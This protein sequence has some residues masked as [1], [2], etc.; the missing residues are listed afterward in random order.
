MTS[1]S[2]YRALLIVYPKSFRNEF[3][4]DIVQLFKDQR[5]HAGRSGLAIWAQALPDL[6]L[7]GMYERKGSIMSKKTLAVIGAVAITELVF[8]GLI[9]VVGGSASRALLVLGIVSL[10][11]LAL[12]GV[13]SLVGRKIEAST[14]E[15]STEKKMSF[16]RLWW[17][18]VPMLFSFVYVVIGV[19]PLVENPSVGDLVPIALGLLLA[20]L[21]IF[22]L[23]SRFRRSDNL[24][25]WA[26]LISC[27]PAFT[28]T[29][30]PPV[31]LLGA[32]GVLGAVSDMFMN[33]RQ[34]SLK[35]A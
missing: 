17:T 13:S 5:I 18:P 10:I 11:A 30:F 6:F 8:A 16:R 32:I 9:V 3:G 4:E 29:W 34:S 15:M 26:I 19:R 27:L 21:A 25:N 35:H 1:E 20:G 31:M 12:L 33:R 22:G 2:A 23:I 24:G 7:S 14:E 28:V